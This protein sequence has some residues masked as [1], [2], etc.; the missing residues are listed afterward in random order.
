MRK[1]HIRSTN[2][3][4]DPGSPFKVKKYIDGGW[5]FPAVSTYLLTYIVFCYNYFYT[6]FA[7]GSAEIF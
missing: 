2:V 4:R 3:T 5:N 1:G 7:L 6:T